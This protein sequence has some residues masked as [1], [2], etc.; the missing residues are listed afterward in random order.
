M[1]Q[2]NTEELGQ[3]GDCCNQKDLG[4]NGQ[5]VKNKDWN[6]RVNGIVFLAVEI[7]KNS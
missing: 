6:F 1:G 3:N 4:T 5:E 7:S 2:R